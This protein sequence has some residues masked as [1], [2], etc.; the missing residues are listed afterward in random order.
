MDQYGMGFDTTYLRDFSQEETDVLQVEQEAWT[1]LSPQINEYIKGFGAYIETYSPKTADLISLFSQVNTG[2]NLLQQWNII[3]ESYRAK[4]KK[5][6]DLVEEKEAAL[7]V[8][9]EQLRQPT[10]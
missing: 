10:K 8:L 3:S 9:I 6:W 4:Y 7:K 5:D 2:W 1:L